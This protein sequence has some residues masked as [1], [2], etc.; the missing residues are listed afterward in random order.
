MSCHGC[1]ISVRKLQGTFFVFFFFTHSRCVSTQRALL[2]S[3]TMGPKGHVQVRRSLANVPLLG[4]A[5]L[6]VFIIVTEIKIVAVVYN[7][8]SIVVTY[9]FLPFVNLTIIF[10]SQ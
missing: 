4:F 10:Y 2:E 8:Y 3:G 7:L 9:F 1:L 5:V 6:S